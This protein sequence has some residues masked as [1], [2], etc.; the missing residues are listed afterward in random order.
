MLLSRT[1]TKRKTRPEGFGGEVG[2]A[3]VNAKNPT[4]ISSSSLGS[5]ELPDK[6]FDIV[7]SLQRSLSEGRVF[8]RPW[9]RGVK[10]CGRRE[11]D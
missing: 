7:L 2:A 1:S 4:L 8:G 10:R 5:E 11:G 9:H 3:D 6:Q